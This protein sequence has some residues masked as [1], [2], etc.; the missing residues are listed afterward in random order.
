MQ[1]SNYWVFVHLIFCFLFVLF[2]FG[3]SQSSPAPQPVDDEILDYTIYPNTTEAP[4]LTFYW[5]AGK[6]T[7][8]PPTVSSISSRYGG[9]EG[10]GGGIYKP[11]F[12][13]ASESE[14]VLTTTREPVYTYSRGT[15][16]YATYESTNAYGQQ[17]GEVLIR[18]GRKYAV[19]HLH[20]IEIQSGITVG[21]T[22]EK[23]TLIGY[24]EKMGGG[25]FW[26]AEIDHIKSSTEVRAVPII[27]YLDAASAQVFNDILTIVGQ[28]SWIHQITESTT[29]S[30]LS[31]VGTHEYWAD[32][33][34]VGVK[35]G[36]TSQ[37]DS[38]VDFCNRHNLSWI[39][40]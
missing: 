40:Q 35:S 31:C 30:W 33:M 13:P 36:K 29:E 2:L 19:K 17:E 1:K 24:T 21:T 10:P 9:W 34:K 4:A 22:V 8:V 37:F 38:A 26:E 14:M 16:V 25:S 3:C 23:G 5:G 7:V 20:V 6:Q 12:E 11:G 28:T 15:V 27:Y 39:L 32:A 18:Y